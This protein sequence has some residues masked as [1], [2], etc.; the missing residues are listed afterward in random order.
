MRS[1][2]HDER[3]S[4]RAHDMMIQ[5]NKEPKTEDADVFAVVVDDGCWHVLYSKPTSM[6]I[7]HVSQCKMNNTES[8]KLM[9]YSNYAKEHLAYIYIYVI[10][11]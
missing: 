5:I 11:V 3:M 2:M 7:S 6:E 1:D 8:L 10:K 9:V 4:V